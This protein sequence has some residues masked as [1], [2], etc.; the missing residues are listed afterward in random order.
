MCAGATVLRRQ[1]QLM[2]D[3]DPRF[4][5]RSRGS[6]DLAT[7]FYQP[8]NGSRYD[9]HASCSMAI[10]LPRQACACW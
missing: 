6:G 4:H 8:G 2:G 5:G 1:V 9:A 7:G 3:A 10:Q